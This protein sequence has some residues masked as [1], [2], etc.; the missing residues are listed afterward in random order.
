MSTVAKDILIPDTGVFR[1]AFLYVG[2][3]DSTLFVIPDGS[4]FKYVLMDINNDKKNGGIDVVK[5]LKDLLNDEDDLVFIN[6]HPHNDHLKGIKK[7]HD[8]L[9][10]T[11]VWHSGHKPG[12][13]HDDA[14]QELQDVIKDIGD[15]NE[16]VLFGSNDMNKV[17]M[18]DRTTEVEKKLGEIDYNILSP[19]EYVQDEVDG[20]DAQ[21]RYNRIHERCAVMKLIYGSPEVKSILMTGD[22]D[23]KAWKEHIT[24]YHEDKLPCD[25]LSASHHG[26]RTF[27]KDKED[28]EDVYRSHID[29]MEPGHLVVSAPKQTESRHGHPHDDAIDLYEEYVDEDNIYHLGKN[30]ECVIVDINSDG[31]IDLKLDQD[32]VAE[33]GFDDDEDDTSSKTK[34]ALPYVGSRTTRIDR[35]P[36]GL[37]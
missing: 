6:T 36:M 31:I 14:Y 22:S 1:I 20:E 25:V 19:A 7:I 5:M 21:G 17:R 30:R 3:G 9:G 2:Q 13:D 4:A 16:Y 29:K 10:I 32:L 27:F 8:E 23:K 11:E 24:D 37:R 18:N 33:Y 34:Y 15:E 35:K 26:S 28:D 12:S